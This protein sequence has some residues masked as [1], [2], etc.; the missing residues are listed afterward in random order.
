M[1]LSRRASVVVAIAA[2]PV[3]AA[4]VMPDA[5]SKLQKDI[6]DVQQQLRQVERGQQELRGQVAEIVNGAAEREATVSREE[7]AALQL[8]VEQSS[9][10]TAVTAERVG[11]LGQRL[12]RYSQELQ[13]TRELARRGLSAG[14]PGP[15]A[16]TVVDPALAAEPRAAQ[17]APAPVGG[18]AFPDPE[19]LYNTSY[20]D[21]SKG[22]YAL[23]ISGFEEY[24]QRF[25]DSA[26]ADNALYWIAECQFSQGS[27]RA[28]VETLDDLLDRYPESDKAAA[29]N[30]KKA[31]AFQEQNLIQQAIIQYRYVVSAY[32]A[33]DEARL[34]R[35]KLGGLGAAPH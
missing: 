24:Q 13:Q 25:P 26:L 29:A 32:P 2:L 1:K 18:A 3:T 6:A 34:A 28:A 19:G 30:L 27:Y 10:Q 7:L 5:V 14:G 31:L 23:A 20:A 35:D 9:R 12:D 17:A 15:G 16:E 4:C 22:N 11:E 33:T 21:F 8:R